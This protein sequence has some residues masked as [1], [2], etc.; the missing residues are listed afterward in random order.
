MVTVHG[1]TSPIVDPFSTD[2]VAHDGRRVY[3]R[4]TAK[5]KRVNSI[6]WID[7]T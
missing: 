3:E 7:D 1:P 5:N 2:V 4:L 6:A